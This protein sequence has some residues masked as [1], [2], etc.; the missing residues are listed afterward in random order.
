MAEVKI[1]RRPGQDFIAITITPGTDPVILT[2]DEAKILSRSIAD[3]VRKVK[4]TFGE[5]GGG[6]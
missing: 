2:A 6:L 4:R 1:V 5:G 3:A